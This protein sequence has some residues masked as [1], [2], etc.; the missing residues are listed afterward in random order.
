MYLHLIICLSVDKW[1]SANIIFD[2][3][4]KERMQ[5]SATITRGRQWPC[6][7]IPWQLKSQVARSHRID[8]ILQKYS[9]FSIIKVRW[10][11]LLYCANLSLIDSILIGFRLS[12]RCPCTIGPQRPPPYQHGLPLILEVIKIT[13]IIKC[14]IKSLTNFK[15]SP[16]GTKLKY[17]LELERSSIPGMCVF[18]NVNR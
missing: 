14:R 6:F 16:C 4:T 8:L 13:A 17:K 15:F 1:L 2:V 5:L 10:Y 11:W 18:M 3:S 9:D 12:W 7:P